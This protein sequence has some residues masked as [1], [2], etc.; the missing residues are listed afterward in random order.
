MMTLLTP[1][2]DT[3]RTGHDQGAPSAPVVTLG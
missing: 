2:L 1:V 3:P